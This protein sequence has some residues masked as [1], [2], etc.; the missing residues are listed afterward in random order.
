MTFISQHKLIIIIAV[1]VVA[2]GVWYGLSGST[3]SSPA[4]ITTTSVGGDAD[5]ELVST[6]LALRAVKLEGTIFS[7]PA[8]VNLKDFSTQI[9][10]EAVGRPNPFAPL[11]A[12]ATSSSASSAHAAQLFTPPH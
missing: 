1:I 7:D 5:Q 2:G 3:S 8:F 10:P 4:L 12:S 6:L 11:T 9:I